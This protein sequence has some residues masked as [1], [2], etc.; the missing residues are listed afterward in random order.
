MR[1]NIEEQMEIGEVAIADVEIDTKSRDEIPKV[2]FGLQSIYINKIVKCQVF[3]ALKGIIPKDVNPD[4]GCPG[5]NLWTILVLGVL[6][7]CCNWD[8]DKLL[9]IANN[10]K[11]VR[12]MLGISIFN[13]KQFKLQTLKDN[14]SLFKPDVLDKINQIVVN[15]GHKVLGKKSGEELRGSCDSSVV[16]TNV[17]Y[18]TDINLLFDAMRKVLIAIMFL[19]DQLCLPGWRK[20]IFNLKKVKKLFIT[21][22]RLKHSSSKNEDKKKERKQVIIKAHSAYIELCETIIIKIKAAIASI[23]SEDVKILTI[24]LQINGYIVHAERQIDLIKRRIVNG[25]TIPHHEKVFSIFEEHTRWIKKGKGGVPQEL[26]LPV[27]FVKDQYGFILY[28]YV[29][30]SETDDKVAVPVVKEVIKRFPDFNSCSFDKGFHSPYNQEE[31]KKI[32]N[33]VFLPRKGK[34]S[35]INKEIENSEEFKKARRKHAAVESSIGALQNHGLDRCPDRGIKGFKRYVALGVLAR[36][37]QIL[38]HA[39]QQK[40]LKRQK[41]EKKRERI[42]L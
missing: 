34:L 14:I 42:I 12:L 36:N 32:L 39:V 9:D 26:G 38:G 10:H 7:L 37:I 31:L 23:S 21:A 5:M 30:Q 27:C 15:F 19:C 13:N 11:T 16:K 2:L 28:H 41:K 35:A 22:Q 3:D 20:G 17:H 33:K 29:M 1:K 18:P 4:I 25:E 6:R 8:Y 40:E 24:I